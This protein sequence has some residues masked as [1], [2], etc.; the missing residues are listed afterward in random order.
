MNK[1]MD[2]QTVLNKL[3]IKDFRHLSK[4]NVM[5]FVSMIPDMDPDVAKAAI[6]Q[7]P[8]FAK[9]IKSIMSDYKQEIDSALESNDKSMKACHEAA[10]LILNS[11][12]KILDNDNLTHEEEMEIAEKMIEVQKLVNDKD[13]QNKKFIIGMTCIASAVTIIAVGTVSTLLGGKIQLPKGK[14]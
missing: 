13:T 12:D 10:K 3:G 1:K 7:F 8:E 14:N 9:T 4:D 5:E 2:E 11:L 6:N